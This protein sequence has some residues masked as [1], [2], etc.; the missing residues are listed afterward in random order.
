VAALLQ[1]RVFG[2]GL[3]EDEDV[4]VGVF[5]E[6]EEILISRLGLRA[7]ALHGIGSADLKMGECSDGFVDYNSAMVENFL[8]LG[9]DFAALVRGKIGFS[10]HVDGI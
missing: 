8:E 10:A 4:G 1:L 2:F 5:P 7:V 9:D 6:R 3:L